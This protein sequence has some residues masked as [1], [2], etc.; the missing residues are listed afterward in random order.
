MEKITTKG[1]VFLRIIYWILLNGDKIMCVHEHFIDLVAS[2]DTLVLSAKSIMCWRVNRLVRLHFSLN[3][4]FE[5]FGVMEVFFLLG[6]KL[7]VWLRSGG[8]LWFNLL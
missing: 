3:C 2:T 8:H 1:P 5:R 6:A 7:H 4:F